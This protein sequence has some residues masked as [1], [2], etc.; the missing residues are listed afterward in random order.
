MDVPCTSTHI[1]PQVHTLTYILSQIHSDIPNSHTHTFTHTFVHNYIV[2]HT[3]T[4][5]L[6]HQIFTYPL[7]LSPHSSSIHTHTPG[8][9]H[10]QTQAQK[11]WLCCYPT[12]SP[13][14]RV[15]SFSAEWCP[16]PCQ[17]GWEGHRLAGA[18]LRRSGW[19]LPGEGQ[20]GVPDPKLR[21]RESIFP[22]PAPSP[23]IRPG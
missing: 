3:H 14:P 18:P 21:A 8:C 7:K 11:S 19:A 23:G 15:A 16:H 4:H 22:T 13:M 2:S 9:R 6:T 20:G 1:F 5:T 10:T 12:S 17:A